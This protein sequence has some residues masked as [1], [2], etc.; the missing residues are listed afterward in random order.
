[1]QFLLGRFGCREDL[2]LVSFF[3]I[4]KQWAIPLFSASVSVVEVV[5]SCDALGAHITEGS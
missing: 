3:D 4:V 5:I 1:L 2:P